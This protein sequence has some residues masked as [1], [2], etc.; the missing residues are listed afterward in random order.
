MAPAMSRDKHVELVE[1]H[2]V[3]VAFLVID[4]M[5]TTALDALLNYFEACRG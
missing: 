3:D 5:T 4:N 2:R 1:S